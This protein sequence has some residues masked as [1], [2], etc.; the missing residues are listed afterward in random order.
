MC[1]AISYGKKPFYN[2]GPRFLGAEGAAIGQ[3]SWMRE[4]TLGGNR[5]KDEVQRLDWKTEGEKAT[6]RIRTER[7]SKATTQKAT[8]DA[9]DVELGPMQIRTFVVEF[10]SI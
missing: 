6:S 8:N 1:I 3:L 5:W 7:G 2:I 9:F 10:E 4:T